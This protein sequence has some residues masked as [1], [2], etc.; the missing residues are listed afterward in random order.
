MQIE[1]L[2]FRQRRRESPTEEVFFLSPS[3]LPHALSQLVFLRFCEG[4]SDRRL[5]TL[6]LV[7]R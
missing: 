2:E 5:A 7:T 6:P 1:F 3:F 4:I